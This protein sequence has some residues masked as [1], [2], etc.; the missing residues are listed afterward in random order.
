ML[1]YT[2]KRID[3][4]INTIK[5][6]VNK[7]P[8]YGHNVI[9]ETLEGLVIR[10]K[11]IL[12][13]YNALMYAYG[14]CAVTHFITTNNME[15]FKGYC[16]L[17]AKA[18]E[19]CFQLYE[20]GIRTSLSWGKHLEK[21]DNM[22]NYI[23]YAI[24]ANRYELA[25]RMTSPE[26]LLGSILRKDYDKAKTFLPENPKGFQKDWEDEERILWAIA[27][28]NEKKL[29]QFME[30]RI[31]DLRR[32]ANVA[33]PICLDKWGLAWI[34]LARQREMICKLNVIELPQDMLDDSPIN[35]EKWKLPEDKEVEKILI[36]GISVF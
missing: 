33:M 15:S 29:Y 24:L 10:D 26:T 18:G 3:K 9:A 11:N 20:K 35:E 7:V 25:I 5:R 6:E 13:K 4:E 32:Q 34:K 27:Y 30:R 16:Y 2:T 21:K 36:G 23:H 1:E 22:F 14:H 12:E 31:K 17:A 8:D 19:L 28:K